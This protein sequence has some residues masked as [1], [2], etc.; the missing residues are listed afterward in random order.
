MDGGAQP[1]AALQD[2]I[3]SAE[4]TKR[5]RTAH[6]VILIT[7]G[8]D[9]QKNRLEYVVRGWGARATSWLLEHGQLWGPTSEIEVWHALSDLLENSRYGGEKDGLPIRLALLQDLRGAG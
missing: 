9:V 5:L 3:Q 4:A 7:A 1:P 8:V 2:T 6:R